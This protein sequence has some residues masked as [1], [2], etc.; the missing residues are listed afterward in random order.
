MGIFRIIFLI[1]FIVGVWGSCVSKEQRKS[2]QNGIKELRFFPEGYDNINGFKLQYPMGIRHVMVETSE[3]AYKFLHDPAIIAHHDRLIAAWYNCPEGEIVEESSIRAR[4]SMDGGLTW[5]EPEVIAEDKGKNG[6]FYVPAQLFSNKGNLFAFVG[7]MTAHD[8]IVNTTLYKYDE[9]GSSWIEKGEVAPL[10]LPNCAPV[11][12]SNGSWLISGRVASS[13]G[14]LPLIP[15]V[16]ISDGDDVEGTWRIVKLSET[17]YREDQYPETTV[18]VEGENLVA[19]VRSDGVQNQPDVYWST[20]NGN[21]WEAVKRHD[22]S[23]ISAK[24]YAGRLQDGRGYIV[25]NHLP[26]GKY[27]AYTFDDRQILAISLSENPA[28][29]LHF[30]RTY[31]VQSAG[32]GTPALSHYPSVLEHNGNLYIIYTASFKGETKRQCQL[33][34]IPLA[35]LE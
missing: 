13:L 14:N 24:F 16:M 19:F 30:S 12:L 2:E 1:L 31:K 25:Y 35:S 22:F 32:T 11:Q 27:K 23:A 18:M 28:S 7:K 3:G 17:E 21:S 34:I 33:A 20:D 29:P 15:A 8:R 26:E 5:S 6:I 10:F 4:R 9:Q